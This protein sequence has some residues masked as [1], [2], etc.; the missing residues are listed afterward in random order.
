MK[1][2]DDPP[3]GESLLAKQPEYL[4]TAVMNDY[5]EP[6]VLDSGSGVRLTD[7]DGKAYLD[8]FGGILT[9]SISERLRA[10]S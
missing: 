4:F 5:A 1:R 7:I 3:S 9:V 2:R 10:R 6:V 8:I